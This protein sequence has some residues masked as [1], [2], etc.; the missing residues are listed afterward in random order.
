VCSLDYSQQARLGA[1][2]DFAGGGPLVSPE[3]EKRDRATATFLGTASGQTCGRFFL[4][5]DALE[6]EYLAGGTIELCIIQFVYTCMTD[7]YRELQDKLEAEDLERRWRR[8]SIEMLVIFLVLLGFWA[9]IS[10]LTQ[11]G[12]QP[13]SQ[14]SALLGTG[15]PHSRSD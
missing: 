4:A 2:S 1:K 12:P 11:Y 7:T 13:V 10:L 6:E 9:G 15:K 8:G 3:G 14:G 5:L